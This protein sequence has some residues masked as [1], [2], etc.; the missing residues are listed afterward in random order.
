VRKVSLCVLAVAEYDAVWWEQLRWGE[1]VMKFDARV[2]GIPNHLASAKKYLSKQDFALEVNKFKQAEQRLIDALPA[3]RR[4]INDFFKQ[5][6]DCVS[7]FRCERFNF[8]DPLFEFACFV[9]GTTPE[10][11]QRENAWTASM[12]LLLMG[13]ADSLVV[14]FELAV[15]LSVDVEGRP[16][17]YKICSGP[18]ML[19]E[20]NALDE[21][22]A[23]EHTM[24]RRCFDAFVLLSRQAMERFER[25]EGVGRRFWAKWGVLAL[26]GLLERSLESNAPLIVDP[27]FGAVPVAV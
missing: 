11:V 16:H 26:R 19:Q 17:P 18:R 3:R 9:D 1:K 14:P 10:E 24:G 4:E 27:Q 5:R 22:V 6:V 25:Q 12:N 23:V 20:L 8:L 7:H 13:N 2:V 15:P 21:Y